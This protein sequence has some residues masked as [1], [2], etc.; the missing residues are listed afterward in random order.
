MKRHIVALDHGAV[1]VGIGFSFESQMWNIGER[2]IG[3]GTG[4]LSCAAKSWRVD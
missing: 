4:F 1:T 3:S 2:G